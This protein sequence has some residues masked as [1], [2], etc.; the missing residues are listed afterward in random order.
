ME[1]NTLDDSAQ[2]TEHNFFKKKYL[3]FIV[4]GVIILLISY[5]PFFSIESRESPGLPGWLIQPIIWLAISLVLQGVGTWFISWILFEFMWVYVLITIKNP[6]DFGPIL[7]IIA[8]IIA[9]MIGAL[10]RAFCSR[11][12]I[13]APMK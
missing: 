13:K 2:K 7:L 1:N 5:I 9:G 8:A 12:E 6:H 11:F 3:T 4:T 10:L